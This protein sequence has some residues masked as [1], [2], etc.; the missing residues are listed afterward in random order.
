[1]KRLAFLTFLL[2]LMTKITIF[3]LPRDDVPVSQYTWKSMVCDGMLVLLMS[4]AE[5]FSEA[6]CQG[7]RLADNPVDLMRR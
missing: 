1:M 4:V 3:P 7:L 6:A 2:L 5:D